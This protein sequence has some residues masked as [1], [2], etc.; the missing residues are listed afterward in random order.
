[1][2]KHV[3]LSKFIN[4]AESGLGIVWTTVLRK[5]PCPICLH[6]A[7]GKSDRH[8]IDHVIPKVE[9]GPEGWENQV[10]MCRPCNSKKNR[11]PLLMFLLDSGSKFTAALKAGAK[12]RVVPSI[13][14]Y[15]LP[16]LHAGWR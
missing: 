16:I 12:Q 7:K 11:T 13:P 5:D 1:V 3:V 4:R 14:W 6:V 8:S 15:D 9:G 2:A 10:G